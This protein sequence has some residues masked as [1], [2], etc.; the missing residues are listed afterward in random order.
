MVKEL[1]QIVTVTKEETD[2]KI[3]LFNDDHNTFE[4]VIKSLIDVC[5]HSSE[6]AEQCAMIVH[7]KGKYAVKHGTPKDLKPRCGALLERGLS[8]E[9]Q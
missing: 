5:D 9:I 2:Y 7:T 1:E 3:V 6:Q 4:W 8:A